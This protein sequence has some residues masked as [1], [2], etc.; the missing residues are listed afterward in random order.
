MTKINC[1]A[2]AVKHNTS[3]QCEGFNM[4]KFDTY[5]PASVIYLHLCT[6][7]AEIGVIGDTHRQCI[8]DYVSNIL[9]CF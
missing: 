2:Y 6:E 5:I 1:P 9:C 7:V 8:V 3:Q 4:Y